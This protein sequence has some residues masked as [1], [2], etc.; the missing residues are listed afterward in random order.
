MSALNANA[1]YPLGHTTETSRVSCTPIYVDRQ[2]G[3]P[4]GKRSTRLRLGLLLLNRTPNA[5]V[6]VTPVD[7]VMTRPAPS[8]FAVFW[9]CRW[10]VGRG[11][12]A[13]DAW[14]VD[15]GCEEESIDRS[16][17]VV[18]RVIRRCLPGPPHRA[19]WPVCWP[20]S[21]RAWALAPDRGHAESGHGRGSEMIHDHGP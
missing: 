8:C 11:G 12:H 5:D 7:D 10:S 20:S 14:F 1:P 2:T 3:R 6:V 21:A 17:T 16:F 19:R 4:A 9:R 18:V 15:L 13:G